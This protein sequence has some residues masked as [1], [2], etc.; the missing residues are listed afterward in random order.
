MAA[1]SGIPRPRAATVAPQP[2][3]HP[4][5]YKQAGQ[6]VYH[7]LTA[8]HAQRQLARKPP[9]DADI[10]E[11]STTLQKISQRC[12]KLVRFRVFCGFGLALALDSADFFL[13][14]LP[15]FWR[16]AYHVGVLRAMT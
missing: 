5:R 15:E 12:F 11:L 3:Q 13:P 6:I 9:A 2:G 8:V 10:S 16:F 4:A 14:T 1:A 7:S